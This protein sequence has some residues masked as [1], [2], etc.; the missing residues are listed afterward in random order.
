VSIR[1]IAAVVILHL[2]LFA[3]IIAL[4]QE[5]DIVLPDFDLELALAEE[6][7]PENSTPLPEWVKPIRW[8]RS[9]KAGMALEEIQSRLAALRNEYALSINFAQ[10]DELPEYLLS[11]FD[12]NYF[13]EIRILY[14][15]GEKTRTQW[16]FRDTEGTTRLDAV[17]QEQPESDKDSLAMEIPETA[18]MNEE[19]AYGDFFE[20]EIA[21]VNDNNNINMPRGVGFIEIFD[22]NSYLI[23]EYMFFEN[24][25]KQKTDYAY[26]NNILIS[27][28]VLLCKNNE[29]YKPVYIDFLRY[30][31]SSYLRSIE[32]VFYTDMQMLSDDVVRIAFPRRIMDAAGDGF[33]INERLNAYPEFFGDIFI[34][35]NSRIVYET[36]E[37]SRITKQ[38]LYDEEGKV[39][40]VIR[41]IWRNDRIVS[42]YKTEG[43]T[44]LLAEFE[45]NSDGER[46]LE[47]NFKNGVLERSVR[48]EGIN[49]IEEL[50]LNNVIILRAVW[51][52]GRKISETR[53][54]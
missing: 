38:T 39:I 10:R 30:N 34:H 31:R 9:N 36:D 7:N 43:D 8:F 35:I 19:E 3:G 2:L 11:F 51:E 50:Y 54:R 14:K 46:I 22:K 40:W 20:N 16:L 26:N 5:L 15:N 4:A 24:G 49:D 42:T 12:E 37:R 53:M 6:G 45:Y 28:A 21:A 32:R 23:C 13:I 33:F 52:D 47:R 27:S 25:E 44:E 1:K 18:A 48:T 41:N 29:D 17:F